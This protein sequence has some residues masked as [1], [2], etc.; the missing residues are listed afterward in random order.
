MDGAAGA[1]LT[2][3]RR[4]A[5]AVS[6]SAMVVSASAMWVYL[7]VGADLVLTPEVVRTHGRILDSLGGVFVVSLCVFVWSVVRRRRARKTETSARLRKE[8]NAA[9]VDD[10]KS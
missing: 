7:R 1:P 5:M 2:L 9:A 8:V 10:S 3:N 6:A 4:A